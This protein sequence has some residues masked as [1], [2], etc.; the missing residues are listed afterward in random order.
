M[1]V[2]KYVFG[3]YLIGVVAVLQGIAWL[4]GKD[5]AVFAFT[6]AVI[7]AVGGIL[8]GIKLPIKQGE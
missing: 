5:G 2:N 6:S 8:L 1:T 4:L 3:M 7:G